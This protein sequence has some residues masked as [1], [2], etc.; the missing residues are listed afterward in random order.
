MKNI[1]WGNVWFSIKNRKKCYS[2][3]SL[4]SVHAENK[5]NRKKNALC[6][7]CFRAPPT[8]TK[9]FLL[10]PARIYSNKY[11]NTHIAFVVHTSQENALCKIH[12]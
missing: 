3:A 7:M 8:N 11:G 4:K 10:F 1:L 12:F 5:F 2:G 6:R 9:V